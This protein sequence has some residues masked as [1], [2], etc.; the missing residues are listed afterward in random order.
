[1]Q[2]AAGA[3]IVS[4]GGAVL[5]EDDARLERLVARLREPLQSEPPAQPS[6]EQ[7]ACSTSQVPVSSL[8]DTLDSGCAL[9][10]CWALLRERQSPP[11]PC[12]VTWKVCSRAGPLK[13]VLRCAQC[14]AA[15]MLQLEAAQKR[16]DGAAAALQEE[17]SAH[18][19][20]LRHKNREL[21]EAQVRPI[22]AIP[23]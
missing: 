23:I 22:H 16:A 5:S 8:L 17:R 20:V 10:L 1:M 6:H 18:R 4:A 11:E 21:A 2:R 3:P 14:Q 19:R 15:P 9:H 13:I 12:S 7:H